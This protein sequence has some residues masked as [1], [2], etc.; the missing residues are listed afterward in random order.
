[1][2]LTVEPSKPRLCN[3][4]RFLNLWIADRPF[5]LDHLRD[6]ARYSVDLMA[7]PSNVRLGLDSSPLLFLLPFPYLIVLALIFL[8]RIFPSFA[9]VSL[10]TLMFFL[11]FPLS[12]L[13]SVFFC[14]P[15]CRFLLFQIFN[16][17]DIGGLFCVP[18]HHPLSNLI[19]KGYW[20]LSLFRLR[21][22]FP[23]SGLLPGS[24]GF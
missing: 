10:L 16:L 17:G 15:A 24:L 11:Q 5:Q 7:L 23:S 18:Q 21:K 4:N 22:V 19:L 1:M 13:S 2:P 9:E 20:V 6:V 3:D 14:R 12:P 8:P